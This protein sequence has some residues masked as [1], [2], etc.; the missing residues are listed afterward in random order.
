MSQQKR[1]WIKSCFSQNLTQ[2]YEK[3]K[4]H[5][6]EQTT[7]PRFLVRKKEIQTFSVKFTK[8][9][10]RW[11]KVRYGRAQKQMEN[12]RCSLTL[13]KQNLVLSFHYGNLNRLHYLMISQGVVSSVVRALSCHSLGPELDSS[14]WRSHWGL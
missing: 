2:Y 3:D 7:Y 4:A 8:T 11:S 1:K 12:N 13:G 5:Y 9:E 6:T 10:G 14:L